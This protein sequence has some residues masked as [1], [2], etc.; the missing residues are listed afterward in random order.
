VADTTL[1]IEAGGDTGTTTQA[2]RNIK[3]ESVFGTA[4]EV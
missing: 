1:T 4:C 3:P 2:V